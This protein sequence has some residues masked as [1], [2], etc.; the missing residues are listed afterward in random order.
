MK[1]KEFVGKSDDQLLEMLESYKKEL[2]HL[3]FQLSGGVLKNTSRVKFVR[4]TV[5]KIKTL[6]NNSRPSSIG[7]K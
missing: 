5:A 2:M 6:I 3:R 7:D 4:K 1:M